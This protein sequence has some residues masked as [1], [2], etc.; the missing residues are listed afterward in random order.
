M[1][2]ALGRPLRG[3]RWH[4]GLLLGSSRARTGVFVYN[5]GKA[6]DGHLWPLAWVRK[7]HA[8]SLIFILG[9]LQV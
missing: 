7:L 5:E 9:C 6:A 8:D 3:K 4:D 2:L 1:V